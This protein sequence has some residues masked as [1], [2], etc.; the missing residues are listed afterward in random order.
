MGF[1]MMHD[2]LNKT[3]DN[4]PPIPETVVE[5]R[6]YIDQSGPDVQV[7]KVVD[8]ISKDPLLTADLL[9]L[10]NS[11]YYG[12][13]REISTLNQVVALLGVG[14]IKNIAIAN[15]LKGKLHIDVSPYGLDTSD[16]LRNSS[17]EV[18]FI[19]EWLGEEDKRLSQEIVPCAMLLRLGMILFSSVLI[20]SGRDKEF[21]D[22][23]KENEFR[24]VAIVENEFFGTDHLSFSGF[25]FNHWKFDE[26]L[27]ESLAY[28]TTPH[29][30]SDAVK[31]NSYALAIANRIFEPYQ[32]GS[33][34]NVHD[35]VALIKEAA[36]QGIRFNL[37]LF[38]DKLPQR[39]RDNLAKS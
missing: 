37:E 6:N 20:Q 26:G 15:S 39:A 35:A 21:L 25:L 17:E 11:P 16:F 8:I 38:R 29:A 28:I 7:K 34:Y 33:E 22:L 10:A 14:N 13:S 36:T 24:N 9:R 31:K 19:T 2:L 12:F 30:A 23:I 5:L 32:G 3:I 4:L 18:S 1:D 27:I